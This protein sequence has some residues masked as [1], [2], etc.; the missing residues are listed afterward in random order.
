MKQGFDSD[1]KNQET[2]ENRLA[3]LIKE[4]G[5][6]ARARKREALAWHFE[7]LQTV[8]GEAVS[9]RQDSITR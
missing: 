3:A 6:E 1:D 7:K 2:A 4:A 9:R 5:D 8:I